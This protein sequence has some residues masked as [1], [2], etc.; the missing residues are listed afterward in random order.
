MMMKGNFLSQQ[1]QQVVMEENLSNLTSASGEATAS[2]SSANKN[3]FPNQYFTPQTQQP[4]PPKKKRNLPGNPGKI[5]HHLI[6]SDTMLEHYCTNELIDYS[7]F[8]V[9]GWSEFN[10]LFVFQIES[11]RV[12]YWVESMG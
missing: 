8:K 7:K 10:G 6:D 2:V 12:C 9:L 5:F 1:Q 4:P 3:E 11:S